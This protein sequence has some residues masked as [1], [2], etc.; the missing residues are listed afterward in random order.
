MILSSD[1]DS[2]SNSVKILLKTS[3][4]ETETGQLVVKKF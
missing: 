1:V 4:K 2:Q 3:S